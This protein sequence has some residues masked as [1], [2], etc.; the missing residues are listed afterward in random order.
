M[1]AAIASHLTNLK[2]ALLSLKAAGAKGF[3]G[4]I[5]VALAEVADAPFRLAG[6][7]SQFGLDGR[8]SYKGDGILY[9]CKRYKRN[10]PRSEVMS[11]IAELGLDSGLD[12]DVWALCATVPITSQVVDDAREAG[13]KIG[14]NILFLDWSEI[15]LPPL[16]VVLAMGGKNVESFLSAYVKEKAQSKAAIAALTAVRAAPDY[17]SHAAR[18]REILNDAS[19]ARDKAREA[20]STWLQETF[21]QRRRAVDRLGQPLSPD[22][23]STIKALNR[24][25]LENQVMSFMTAASGERVLFILG[26][27]GVGKSWLVA[28][29]WMTL[30][31]KPLTLF[32]TPDEFDKFS[33]KDD[34]DSLLIGN[35]VQQ[36][37]GDASAV[38]HKQ[39][40]RRFSNWRL[41]PNPENPRLIVVIDGLNQR[42]L[43]DWARAIDRLNTALEEVG[44]R[45]IVTTRTAHY[46]SRVKNRLLSSKLEVRVT[47]WTPAERETLLTQ[48]GIDN[49]ELRETV[50]AALRNPRL[51]G[52][53]VDLFQKS[54][55]EHMKE[56]SV[57]RL[58]FEHMRMSERDAPTP[59]PVFEFAKH[60]QVHA[61][62]VISRITSQQRDNLRIFE[63]GIEAVA[64]GRFFL[65]VE[66]DPGSYELSEDGLTLALG[67]SVVS[68]LLTAQ[69]SKRDLSEALK[70]V[71]E[72]I[73]A[74]DRTAHIIIAA[75][76][77]ACVGDQHSDDIAAALVEA[78]TELQNPDQDEYEG[79]RGLART[80]TTAFTKAAR[81]IY[82]TRARRLNADWVEA[83]LL[84]FSATDP[85]WQVISDAVCEWL[86]LHSLAPDLH[87]AP[88][89]SGQT[90]E[91]VQKDIEKRRNQINRSLQE[92]S[93]HE[94]ALLST[95]SET[96]G[97]LSTLARLAFALVA[98]K[99]VAS[100]AKHLVLWCFTTSLNSDLWL[101]RREFQH[102]VCLNSN[103]WRA[104][105][106]ALLTYSADLQREGTSKTGQWA[107]V[108][109]LRA[110]GDPVD[111]AHAESIARAL[112]DGREFARSRRRIEDYCASDPCDPESRKPDNIVGTAKR[113]AELD[114]SKLRTDRNPT[115]DIHFFV[116]ACPGVVRFEK[117]IGLEKHREFADDVLRRGGYS[118]YQGLLELENHVALLGRDRALQFLALVKRQDALDSLSE[119]QRWITA[120]Y[121]LL[122]AFPYLNGKEQIEAILEPASGDNVL[123]KT[124]DSAKP[125][126]D[127]TL[128]RMLFEALEAEDERSQFLLLAFA[129]LSGTPL[130][131]S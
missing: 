80:R 64:D 19:L 68:H 94:E 27:E 100:F 15:A 131:S 63:G 24:T 45:L 70:A 40:K 130:S 89:H 123:L 76:N 85:Q 53:A 120:Q 109:V 112:A 23:P 60:L 121:P 127:A 38:Y 10:V 58:L 25:D 50:A 104:A 51:L 12:V 54:E 31:E 108:S 52:I 113:Y 95:S 30:K 41:H 62:E 33:T 18:L 128:V 42:P 98:G 114:V 126:E 34:A 26:D 97:D 125:I 110:T 73:A 99:P 88:R 13:D 84:S 82:L 57:S 90:E 8:T 32:L 93:A 129:R 119:N 71:T 67:F 1:T 49:R 124:L 107:R 20:N 103:D 28:K 115:S 21:S 4:L 105:R 2:T 72:P 44:G 79:F 117:K 46:Q 118:L 36:A 78:F 9:E 39:W 3:E 96:S 35:L 65:P 47:E 55:I 6:S 56:L 14:L 91:K 77:I 59:K 16:A 92:L 43:I 86:S 48:I 17:E 106:D 83:A 5:G 61:T 116:D 111:A 75:L 66:G 102:L 22:D 11:K 101:P 74:L 37:G 81:H 29:S 7:G 87:I 122:L 69:H